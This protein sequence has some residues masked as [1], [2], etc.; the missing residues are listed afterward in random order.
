M[1]WVEADLRSNLARSRLLAGLAL[2]AAYV[3]VGRLGLLLAVPPG[4]A[5]AIFPPAGIA[6]AA[7]F[8][9]GRV[10]LPWIFLGSF[11]LNLWAGYS[12]DR[13]L[14]ALAVA[15]ALVIASASM[16]QAAIGGSA[17]R[18]LVGYPAS[19]DN[20][21][22]LA[23]FFLSAPVLC[24]ISATLSLGGMAALGAIDSS[25][26]PTS[27][28][29]WWIGDTLG[30]LLLLPIIMIAAG[31][32]R[33]LWRGRTLPVA[34]PLLLFFAL[35]VAIFNRVSVWENEQ[36]LLEF[37]ILSQQV[38][39]RLQS[40][41]GAQQVFLEQLSR[42]FVGPARLARDDFHSLVQD[43]LSRFPFIQAVEWAPRIDEAHRAEFEAAQRPDAPGFEIRELDDRGTLR[44]AGGRPEL[45][46]VTYIEPL[47]GNEPALGFDLASEPKRRE[48]IAR[49]IATASVT[50][51]APIRLVQE[52]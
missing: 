46:P 30:V 49:S 18:R 51:T 8:I 21:R 31:E 52:T 23:R 28:L 3:V 43:L 34:V 25:D 12:A 9:G 7:M 24:L 14:N 47:H 1:L 38:L 50:A 48:A 11:L 32:P 37:R 10:T 5:T 41:L 6:M 26:L 2:V 20:G 33:A 45:Y 19:L 40:R 22:D 13:G 42:S 36:S 27:W 15:V 17:L 4:Y 29:T 44:S 16:L 39:D 35:F